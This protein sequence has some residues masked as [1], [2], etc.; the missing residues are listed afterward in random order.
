MKKKKLIHIENVAF[1]FNGRTLF[2]RLN[3]DIF[4]R[5]FFLLVGK[6]GS[7]LTTFLRLLSGLIKPTE[8]RVEVFNVDIHN[9]SQHQLMKV[10]QRIG[11]VFQHSALLNNMTLL[12]NVALP[13]RYH[14]NIKEK[15]CYDIAREKL[16]F[17]GI[18]EY[19]NEL[20]AQLSEEC[21]KRGGLARALALEPELIFCDELTS[22]LGKYH[23]NCIFNLI[24]K[25]TEEK[26][27]TPVIVSHD[28]IVDNKL[29]DKIGVLRNGS[30]EMN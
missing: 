26:G 24:E 13:L 27:I 30:I 23:S 15:D 2:D 3:L 1:S 14:M 4:Q 10:R 29:V 7:G 22:G 9:S 8:G 21:L 18:E 25:L 6:S 17:T 19:K 11:F 12:E 28:S 20:P 5:E 16:R